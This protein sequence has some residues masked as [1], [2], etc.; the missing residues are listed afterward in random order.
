[1]HW[2]GSIKVQELKCLFCVIQD[3]GFTQPT[4]LSINSWIVIKTWQCLTIWVFRSRPLFASTPY[5]HLS[6]HLRFVGV[7][8]LHPPRCHWAF[9]EIRFQQW[10]TALDRL[11]LYDAASLRGAHAALLSL[12]TSPLI[13]AL[14]IE[15]KD[16]WKMS[17]S[18]K[19]MMQI[20]GCRTVLI[21]NVAPF[22]HGINCRHQL[23]RLR[24]YL[25]LASVA[26]D[27][28]ICCRRLG[29]WYS[30]ST[31]K[32]W[33]SEKETPQTPNRHQCRAPSH[34]APVQSGQIQFRLDRSARAAQ[35]WRVFALITPPPSVFKRTRQ[36]ITRA[37]QIAAAARCPLDNCFL[38]CFTPPRFSNLGFVTLWVEG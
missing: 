29:T 34:D 38:L 17:T 22:S 3:A 9:L 12:P 2:E 16:V 37:W 7:V 20:C 13:L 4:I 26:R 33:S 18:E 6:L 28:G 10:E 36:W 32:F 15:S 24:N 23:L 25:C 27:T 1:M 35:W 21:Q 5:V 19:I 14:M 11:Y 31:V 8:W 30:D